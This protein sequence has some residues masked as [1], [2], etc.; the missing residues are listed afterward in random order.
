V[1]ANTPSRTAQYMALFRA[2]E[3]ERPAGKRLFNDKF[4]ISFLDSGLKAATKFS[5]LPI[6]GSIIP[7]IIHNKALGALSSGT[8]R[9]KYIDD[10]LQQTVDSGAKQV[11][12]LGAGFDTRAMRLDFLKNIPVIEIDHPDT[13]VFKVKKL[14]QSGEELPNNIRYLQID[15]NKESLEQLADKQGLNFNIPTAI[16]WEGV[17]NYLTQEAIDTTFDFLKK[18]ADDSYVIFTYIHKQVLDNPQSFAGTEKFFKKL[19]Q[20]EEPW[21]F[22]FLPAELPDYLMRYELKLLEDN[23]ATEYRQKYMPER[24]SL[25]KGYEFYRVAFA[26]K[27]HVTNIL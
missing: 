8:A 22:G 15:F 12:I 20:N 26:R 16:V 9:T 4:A 1:K 11:M 5:G 21:T 6:V 3:N 19:K 17:T 25:L 7:K 27:N 2:I 10:L 13:S 24:K 23:S 14:K 18:F